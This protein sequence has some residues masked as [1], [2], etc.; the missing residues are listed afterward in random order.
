M[1]KIWAMYVDND[2]LCTFPTKEEAFESAKLYLEKVEVC[3]DITVEYD[4]DDTFSIR[5]T[6]ETGI[7]FVVHIVCCE[8]PIYTMYEFVENY[9]GWSQPKSHSHIKVR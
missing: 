2:L 8:T 5:G 6:I 7:H 4:A 9:I 3:K 1:K